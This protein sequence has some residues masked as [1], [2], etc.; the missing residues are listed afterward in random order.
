MSVLCHSGMVGSSG[1]SGRGCHESLNWKI[2]GGLF[3]HLTLYFHEAFWIFR[4]YEVLG[5]LHEDLTSHRVQ[6][7]AS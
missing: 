4:A 3:F 2:S 6:F 1:G 7:S 5:G